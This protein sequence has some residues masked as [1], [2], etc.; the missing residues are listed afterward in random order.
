MNEKMLLNL[1]RE[2]NVGNIT[3]INLFNN[4]IKKIQ[5]L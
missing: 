2:S 5:G 1:C 4:K 3:Y